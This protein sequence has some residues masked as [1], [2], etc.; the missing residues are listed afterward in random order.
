MPGALLDV[1]IAA[2]PDSRGVARVT[3]DPTAVAASAVSDTD[4]HAGLNTLLPG[5]L[6]S[7]KVTSVLRDGLTARLLGVLTATVD[8]Y[9]LGPGLATPKTFKQDQKIKVCVQRGGGEVS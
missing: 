3:S 8:Q 1:V 2:A 7:A 6:V 5:A 9:H 4:A